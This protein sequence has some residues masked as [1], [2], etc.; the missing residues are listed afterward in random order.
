MKTTTLT[1]TTAM[2]EWTK[3]FPKNI[4]ENYTSSV[5]FMKQLTVIA[6][7]TIMYLKD[8]FHDANYTIE[9]FGNIT[10]RILKK[11][12]KDELAQFLSMALVQAFDAFDKKY[13][14]Q[15][16][17]CF[18]DGECKAE[19][20]V[21]YHVFEYTYGDGKTSMSMVSKSRD[22]SESS[23]TCTFGDV[24][25]E[26]L[27]LL[28]A[29]LVVMESCQQQLSQSFDISLRL[30]YNEDAPESYQ[31]PGY[32]SQECE[33]HLAETPSSATILG[34]VR[35]PHHK[36]VA[37]SYF[38]V[39]F[40]ASN[41]ATG[42]LNTPVMTPRDLDETPGAWRSREPMFRC[43][44]GKYGDE[45]SDN[46]MGILICYY[47]NMRQHA[48]C[49]GVLSDRVAY[50]E[51]HCCTECSD[52][53]RARAPTDPRLASLSAKQ[54]ESLC[55]YRRTLVRC[56]ETGVACGAWLSALGVTPRNAAKLLDLLR[57]YGVLPAAQSVLAVCTITITII[58][59][60]SKFRSANQEV[61]QKQL[62]A[63]MKDHFMND[64]KNIVDRLIEETFASQES[65]PDLVGDALAPLD[66]ANLHKTGNL[67]QMVQP[68][69]STAAFEDPILKKYQE[70][71]LS[72]E[73]KEDEMP[74]FEA[75]DKSKNIGK[76][77]RKM[78]TME[79]E[80][81]ALRSGVKTKRA[82]VA[83]K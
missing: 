2:A 47:C 5:T 17:L 56:A 7:S 77:K 68:T 12:C 49:F 29:C 40:K 42:S 80:R 74:L 27:L 32:S 15:L 14:H 11:K 38:K 36:I 78:E 34:S 72:R 52:A 10:L 63:V 83:N 76:G 41:E 61:N 25:R 39:N 48:A 67:G 75:L 6:V 54:R 66:K 37:K 24:R 9:K 81:Q 65:Q 16:A 23:A 62:K 57:S 58:D 50:I 79:S 44:C 60:I 69:P 64:G 21:E 33:D 59:C 4:V 31:A 3:I 73:N 1:P 71:V 8:A 35:T 43:P 26:T 70:A 51:R 22:G 20:L 30:Y 53:G 19:N 18:Y 46:M 82:R 13:L 45:E 55:M 28:Q